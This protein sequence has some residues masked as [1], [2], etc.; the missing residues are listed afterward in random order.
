MEEKRFIYPNYSLYPRS[1]ATRIN[2]HDHLSIDP[3]ETKVTNH[4]SLQ[5]YS[6]I[7]LNYK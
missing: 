4:K 6:A 5:E 7:F 3:S 1:M 2:G